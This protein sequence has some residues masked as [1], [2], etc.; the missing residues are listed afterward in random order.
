MIGV[1]QGLGEEAFAELLIIG[2]KRRRFPYFV[3]F[4]N[5]FDEHLVVVRG[6]DR[7]GESG[8]R[9]ELGRGRRVFEARSAQPPAGF[10]KEAGRIAQDSLARFEG[11]PHRTANAPRGSAGASLSRMKEAQQELRTP[12]DPERPPSRSDARNIRHIKQH[13]RKSIGHDQR[14]TECR[15]LYRHALR[16][17]PATLVANHRVPIGRSGFAAGW[18]ERLGCIVRNKRT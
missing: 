10:R 2:G 18:G 8:R 11:A 5:I 15:I 4:C 9:G 6:R 7:G 13:T 14:G 1:T 12:W 17:T 3:T 16:R